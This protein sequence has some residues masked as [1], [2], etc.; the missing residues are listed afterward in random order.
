LIE[1]G[2]NSTRFSEQALIE[3]AK[4]SDFDS[5]V[6]VPFVSSL[7]CAKSFANGL[8]M[9]GLEWTSSMADCKTQTAKSVD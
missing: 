8:E 3:Q 7:T 9:V 2:L 6:A 5:A 1:L 4:H